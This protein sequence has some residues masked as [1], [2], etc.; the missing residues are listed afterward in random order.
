M[1]MYDYAILGAGL[2]GLSVAKSLKEQDENCSIVIV[3]PTG[4]GGGASGAPI[5]LVNPATGRYA[6]K[7]WR[8]EE[9]IRKVFENFED[10]EKY[11]PTSFF[12]KSGVIRPAADKKIANRMLENFRQTEWK[13]SWVTWLNEDEIN[14][15]Y[16]GLHCVDGGLLIHE[17]ATV[18]IPVYLKALVS[19]LL[20]SD[21]HFKMGSSFELIQLND[22]WK[23]N[24]KKNEAFCASNLIITAGIKSSSI[25]PFND[26]PLIAV[27]GQL[28]L[29][30]N[31]QSFPFNQAVSALGYYASLE[32]SIFVAG[33]SYEHKFTH[34]NT[35]KFGAEYV[36]NRLHKIIPELKETAILIKQ[37]SGVRASTPDRMPIVGKHREYNN[38]F[39]LCGLGS[40]GLL[41]SALLGEILAESIVNNSEIPFE[42][43]ITRFS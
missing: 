23:L 3:D 13:D 24:F 25:A 36:T 12:R 6:N 38:C 14:T 28:A 17:A 16:P 5:G 34:E 20:D 2:A 42:V 22:E 31:K 40:K 30:E 15:Q 19:Y 32:D 29:F 1:T 43:N 35:D 11:S 37:W 33:S 26:L 39:T 27:K 41:Y 21:V 4:I 8:A 7:S 9:S 10:V 18:A